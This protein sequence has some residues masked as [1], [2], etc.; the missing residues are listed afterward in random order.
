[1]RCEIKNVYKSFKKHIIFSN[2]SISFS[3]PGFYL[4]TGASGQGKTTLL[5][6]IA[7]YEPIDQGEIIIENAD[8]SY[9]FQTYELIDH[10]TVLENI[11]MFSDLHGLAFDDELLVKLGIAEL[12]KHYPCELSGG[13]K[14]LVGIARALYQNPHI[15]ICDEPTESLDIDNKEKVL[16]LLKELSEDRV[17]IVSSHD[18]VLL[19]DYYDYHYEIKNKTLVCLEDKVS[20]KSM[21]ISSKLPPFKKDVLKKYINKMIYKQNILFFI[22]LF[23]LILFQS[24]IYTFDRTQLREKSSLDAINGNIIYVTSFNHDLEDLS[25][26]DCEIKPIVYFNPVE[27]NG[28]KI[29]VNIV[30][31]EKDEF[32][33]E[34]NE[35]IINQQM[36]DFFEGKTRQSIVG[37]EIKMSYTISI[38]NY[39][40]VFV[41][42]E[43]IEETDAYVPQIYYNNQYLIDEND[44]DYFE[45]ICKENTKEIYDYLKDQTDLLVSHSIYDGREQT[46]KYRYLYSLLFRILEVACLVAIS[47]SMIYFTNKA[48]KKDK[49]MLSILFT[50]QIP[51]KFVKRYYF[52]E[53]IKY[54]LILELCLMGLLFGSSYFMSHFPIKE[55]LLLLFYYFVCYTFSVVGELMKFTQNEIANVLK[56]NKD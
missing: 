50:L 52:Y 39:E 34:E 2:L 1:M 40:E 51:L 32:N 44:T 37:E 28:K 15:I 22:V 29:Q 38:L 7:G 10:L 5:N 55:L 19:K 45:V 48:M 21:S 49:V 12:K 25:Q 27:I 9:I 46:A 24:V 11:Q 3:K 26:Y 41:I 36:L 14:Q 16:S 53:K 4:L 33:L 43:V 31:L 8:V 18:Y 23:V 20:Q 54:I 30:P 6:M 13:Q 42:K 35:I 47:V 17:V 56:E